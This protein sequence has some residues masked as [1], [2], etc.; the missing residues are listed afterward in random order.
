M[1]LEDDVRETPRAARTASG[2]GPVRYRAQRGDR[3]IGL[4]GQ[5]VDDYWAW[6]YG[7][8]VGNTNRGVLA[9]YIVG[10][11]LGVLTQ[12]RGAWDAFDHRYGEHGIEVKASAYLQTWEQRKLSTI[13][14]GIAPHWTDNT[15]KV[16][17]NECIRHA[18]CY[19][20][21]LLTTTD[22]DAVNPLDL[23]QWAFYVVPTA[24]LPPGDTIGLGGIC[25]IASRVSWDQLRAE[26]D[27]ALQVR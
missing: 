15:D 13:R 24:K 1:S 8:L 21:C 6:A 18:D 3:F 26:V 4:S 9:E 11:A 23:S 19:V 5:T 2:I 10:A 25:K 14:F 17:A 20:F 22:P 7:S 12:H 27:R 16:A